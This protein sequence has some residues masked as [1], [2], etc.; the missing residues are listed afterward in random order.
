[1]QAHDQDIAAMWQAIDEL[2]F[3]RIKAKLIHRSRGKLTEQAVALAEV[4]YR[5]FL[6][7][8]AKYPDVPVVPN[9]EIDEFWHMHILDTQRYAPDCERIFGRMIHHDP[10]LGVD[11]DAQEQ[12][13]WAALTEASWALTEREFGAAGRVEVQSGAYCVLPLSGPQKSGAY[14]VQPTA[15]A[16][17]GAYCVQPSAQALSG[18]YCVKPTAQASSGAY[19][20][21]PAV[22]APSGAYCVRPMARGAYCVRNT[23]PAGK[24]TGRDQ[25]DS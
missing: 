7:L 22:N 10:Y 5:Q 24:F 21:Q 17:S 13:R 19:C 12:A 18:A 9:E 4:G 8:A 23:D 1:M 20:V 25:L 11:P 6:K 2:D 16:S 14:C 15:R 3:D